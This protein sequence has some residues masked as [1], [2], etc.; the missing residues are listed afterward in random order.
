[1][2]ASLVAWKLKHKKWKK[3]LSSLRSNEDKRKLF[4]IDKVKYKDL[5]Q[6]AVFSQYLVQLNDD[7]K[8]Y[9]TSSEILKSRFN[10]IFHKC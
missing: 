2:Y 3:L 10:F 8:I 1:M 7:S 4:K 5:V 9:L 6:F